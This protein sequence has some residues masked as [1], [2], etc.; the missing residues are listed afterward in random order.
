M[1]I[2]ISAD[3]AYLNLGVSDT[4]CNR[5]LEGSNLA[6][7]DSHVK[8]F[9]AGRIKGDGFQT[10]GTGPASKIGG[11]PAKSQVTSYALG[12]LGMTK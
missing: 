9:D 7:L 5:H 3:N 10:G 6:F 12:S 8:R 11:G 4:P 2:A 1:V